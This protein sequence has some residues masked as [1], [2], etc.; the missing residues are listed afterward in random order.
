MKK[1]QAK[2]TSSLARYLSPR[3]QRKTFLISLILLSFIFHNNANSQ[4]M[5]DQSTLEQCAENLELHA[6]MNANR[7]QILGNVAENPNGT[8]N[9]DS[10]IDSATWGTWNTEM[11]SRTIPVVFHIMHACGEE[12]ISDEQINNAL[13]I[14]IQTEL[15]GKRRFH[16]IV[17][18]N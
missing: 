16:K 13:Q 4:C 14:F 6:E 1:N 10:D 8:N 9:P 5:T 3:N 12:N 7:L 17:K 2:W 18:V 15:N 11:A